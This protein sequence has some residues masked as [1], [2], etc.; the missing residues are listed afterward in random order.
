MPIYLTYSC[1]ED[2]GVH[3][4]PMCHITKVKVVAWLELEPVYN[5]VT[6]LYVSHYTMRN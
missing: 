5:H 4:F 1:G 3:T 6:V 2:K